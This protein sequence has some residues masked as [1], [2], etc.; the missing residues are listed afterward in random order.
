MGGRGLVLEGGLGIIGKDAECVSTE[1]PDG[2]VFIS[3]AEAVLTTL[4]VVV[5][6]GTVVGTIVGVESLGVALAKN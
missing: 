2:E 3:V 6:L 5:A 1:R 4:G